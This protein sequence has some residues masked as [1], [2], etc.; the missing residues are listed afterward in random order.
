LDLPFVVFKLGKIHLFF[1]NIFLIEK[2]S[3][4][5]LIMSDEKD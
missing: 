3:K 4:V 1:T 2:E 5:D